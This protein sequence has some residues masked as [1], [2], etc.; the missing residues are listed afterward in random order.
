VAGVL[1]F[2][3]TQAWIDSGPFGKA[4]SQPVQR[5][6][7]KC[8]RWGSTLTHQKAHRWPPRSRGSGARARFLHAGDDG[9]LPQ[10]ARCSRSR[11]TRVYGYNSGARKRP[12]AFSR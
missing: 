6:E 5:G 11:R 2:T 8:S 10:D 1:A 9:A 7:S 4:L 12:A 3:E